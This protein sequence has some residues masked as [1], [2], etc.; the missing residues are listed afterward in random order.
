MGLNL[1]V[2]LSVSVRLAHSKPS[3]LEGVG[4]ALSDL[5][6]TGCIRSYDNPNNNI[7]LYCLELLQS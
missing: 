7:S 2:E 4:I 1:E 5:A 3:K 6:H